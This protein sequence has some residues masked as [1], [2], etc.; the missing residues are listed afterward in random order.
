MDTLNWIHNAATRHSFWGAGCI[1]FGR[2]SWPGGESDWPAGLWV[3][4]LRLEVLAAEDSAPPSSSIWAPKKAK[5]NLDVD[6]ARVALNTAA[7]ELLTPEQLKGTASGESG[8]HLLWLPAPSKRELLD[9]LSDGDAQ[10]FVVLFVSQI[11]LMALFVP[12]LDKLFGV[13]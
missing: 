5:S 12:V 13:K 6:A 4:D 1:G 3:W 2:K 9:A 10:K 7:K 8:E 11:D